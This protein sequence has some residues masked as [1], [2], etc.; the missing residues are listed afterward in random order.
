M[1]FKK[2]EVLFYIGFFILTLS[3]YVSNIALLKNI[4]NHRL[5]V[6]AI[7]IFL[8]VFYLLLRKDIS[9]K[10]VMLLSISVINFLMVRESTLL[11]FI[12]ILLAVRS[13]KVNRIIQYYFKINA[14]VLLLCTLL[15]PVLLYFD[16]VGT[17]L[18]SGRER[19]TFLFTHP[20][21]YSITFVFTLLAYIYLYKEKITNIRIIIMCVFA[22]V[23]LFIFPK[24]IT[25]V[26]SLLVFLMLFVL[27]QYYKYIRE[28]ILKFALPMFTILL[29]TIICSYYYDFDIP[30]LHNYISGTFEIRFIDAAY[31]LK[32]YKLSF[33]G[34]FINDLGSLV[35]RDGDWVSHWLDLGF[36]RA[37][38]NYGILGFLLFL[39][40]FTR[41]FYYY[42]KNK[43]YFI[44]ILIIVMLIYGLCEWGAFDIMT[45]FPLVF[46]YK[47]LISKKKV[48]KCNARG[49]LNNER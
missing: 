13:I 43:Q 8:I 39:T 7:G 19:Y 29:I 10:V 21:T 1:K 31:A 18:I 24:T 26:I 41:S 44:V 27:T 35:Y 4:N 6:D 28:H 14:F 12:T 20:N 15:Y 49:M 25:A 23:Y 48:M 3:K 5:I 37:L 32:N 46:L 33:F 30:I 2:N 45:A 47:G 34:T 22:I 16:L 17:S 36:V 38:F 9:L 42:V 11:T 40:F